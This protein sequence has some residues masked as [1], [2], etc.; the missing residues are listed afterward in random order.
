MA[1]ENENFGREA[2]LA[3]VLGRAEAADFGHAQIEDD[4]VG[5]ELASLG[6]G[7]EAVPSFAADFE[8]S[9]I[10][11]E[12]ADAATSHFVIIGDQ[13]ARAAIASRR[14]G[15]SL[16][17]RMHERLVFVGHSVRQ[18]ARHGG[19]LSSCGNGD[20]GNEL[21]ARRGGAKLE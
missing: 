6:D 10:G 1:A 17:W 19:R 13:D 2:S 4:Q 15:D 7:L 14:S 9:M 8:V 3:N 21:G 16:G 20:A 12:I 18:S 5:L 11:D